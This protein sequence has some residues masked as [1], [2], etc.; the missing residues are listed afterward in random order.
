MTANPANALLIFAAAVVLGCLLLWPTRGLL[1]RWLRMRETRQRIL[2]EDALKHLYDCQYHT[3]AAT[4]QSLSGALGISGN[5]ASE[6]LN[7]LETLRLARS[8]KEGPELTADGCRYALQVI[9]MHRLW[10]QYLADHTGMAATAWH[11]EA[12]RREH[13]LSP[14]DVEILATKL[15]NPR[16][17]PHGDAIP[18]ATGE[19][20]PA[21]GQPL[22]SLKEG[23]RATIVHV[24]DEP[25]AVYAQLV[26]KALVPGI[27]VQVIETSPE[28]VRF[29]FDG[30]EHSLP[31]VVAA[32]LTVVPLA[33]DQEAE[34]PSERLSVLQPGQKGTVLRVSLACRG[35]QLRRLL[36]L[37]FVPGTVVEAELPSPSGD[38]IAYRVRGSLI[39]LRKEQADLICI[40]RNQNGASKP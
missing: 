2:I 10:E 7:V 9:R 6:L 39:A 34:E 14:G 24:E 5:R 40:S 18:S 3:R 16:Y 4:L 26:A 8:T 15:G 25:E 36:D 38:P 22:T 32:N 21:I 20:A 28:R 31:P 11:A 30:E 1:W 19:I 29:S 13:L 17:D 23:D 12:D 27:R 33:K 37:G 35:V